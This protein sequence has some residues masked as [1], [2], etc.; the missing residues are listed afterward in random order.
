MDYAQETGF[1]HS[2]WK[3]INDPKLKIGFFE[4]QEDGEYNIYAHLGLTPD[5]TIFDKFY[6]KDSPI[7][8]II[9][10][11]LMDKMVAFF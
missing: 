11:G 3:Q 7:S 10:V 1:A 2:D 5:G 4:R 9:K 8:V 6:L